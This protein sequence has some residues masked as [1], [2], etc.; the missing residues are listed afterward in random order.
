MLKKLIILLLSLLMFGC[1]IRVPSNYV[2][3]P[4]EVAI[5][6]PPISGGIPYLGP[7]YYE[8]PP[9]YPYNYYSYNYY[10]YRYYPYRWGYKQFGS[11]FYPYRYGGGSYYR[12]YGYG[13][14]HR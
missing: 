8:G 9:L 5:S 2:Y 3:A 6:P 12:G 14:R 1:V 10:P 11:H 7:S 13:R 4:L